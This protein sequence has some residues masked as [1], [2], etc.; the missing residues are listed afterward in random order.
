M[1]ETNKSIEST[2]TAE[3]RVLLF[4]KDL[5]FGIDFEAHAHHRTL[6][7][8]PSSGKAQKCRCFIGC[9]RIPSFTVPSQ[10]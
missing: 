9:R 6:W 4:M 5:H 7:Q 8:A 10:G 2:R 3:V 1:L